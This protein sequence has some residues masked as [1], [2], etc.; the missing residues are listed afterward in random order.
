MT[1]G[2]KDAQIAV[3]TLRRGACTNVDAS[4]DYLISRGV[5][6]AGQGP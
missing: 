4:L 6:V 3:R 1:G 2:R 5:Q